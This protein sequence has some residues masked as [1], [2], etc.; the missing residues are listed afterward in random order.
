MKNT[1]PLAMGMAKNKPPTSS[2]SKFN[3]FNNNNSKFTAKNLNTKGVKPFI[4]HQG[5]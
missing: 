3:N 2:G 5:K 4:K 1:K